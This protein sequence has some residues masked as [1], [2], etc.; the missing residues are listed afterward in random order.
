VQTLITEA[1]VTDRT[2]EIAAEITRDYADRDLVIV[3]VLK[4][5][6]MFMVDLIR[7]IPLPHEIDFIAV[8]SYGNQTTSSGVVRLLKDLDTNISGRDVLLVEDIV[9]SGRSVDYIRRNFQSREPASIKV[10]TLLDKKERRVMDVDVDYTGFVIPDRF[11]VG[12]GM[13]Y[14]EQYRDLPC[15]GVLVGDEE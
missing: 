6:F 4:G 12:Y 13:D 3:G 14:S 9:D 7:H 10:C 1:E 8:S 15:V 11:V 5:S 2:R